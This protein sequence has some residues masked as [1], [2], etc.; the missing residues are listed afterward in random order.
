MSTIFPVFI[1]TAEVNPAINA[2][3]FMYTFPVHIAAIGVPPVKPAFITAESPGFRF[4][5]FY[6]RFSALFAYIFVRCI[7]G[8][9]DF[10]APAER[11]DRVHRN[12]DRISD[13]RITQALL[14]HIL[15]ILFLQ[16]CHDNSPPRLHFR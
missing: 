6:E 2:G 13:F 11:F 5:R 1:I 16:N 3:Q 12:A 15:Y 10:I 7:M 14:S 9:I 8:G 4:Q